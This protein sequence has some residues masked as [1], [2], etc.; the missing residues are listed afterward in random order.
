MSP[1]RMRDSAPEFCG[2]PGAKTAQ[3]QP[4]MTVADATELLCPSCNLPLTKVQTGDRILWA[5]SN[6]GGR[7]VTVELLRRTFTPESIDPLWTHAIRHEGTSGRPCPS[8]RKPMIDVPLSDAAKIEVDVCLH[9]H[10]VWF[11]RGESESLVPVPPPPS[12]GLTQPAREILAMA[13]VE[14]L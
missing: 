5:C 14:A 1:A 9:C 12:D 10:F 13:K 8:C 3:R 2:R 4:S 6:C 7:A 11:D